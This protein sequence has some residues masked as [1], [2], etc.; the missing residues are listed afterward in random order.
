MVG[1]FGLVVGDGDIFNSGACKESRLC[2][3]AGGEGRSW[4]S[5][6]CALKEIMGMCRLRKDV[7]ESSSK[8]LWL[9]K[10]IFR[11]MLSSH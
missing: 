9:E 5:E 4:Y 3:V 8:S 10:W 7:S 1:L 2:D 11:D 6:L